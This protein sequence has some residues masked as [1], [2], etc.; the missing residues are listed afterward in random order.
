MTVTYC[1]MPCGPAFALVV[2][3]GEVS[4]H[5]CR[6]EAFEEAKRL[7]AAARSAGHQPIYVDLRHALEF[8]ERH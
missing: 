6:Q 5:A 1:I 4:R 2:D 8:P 3:T 7:A